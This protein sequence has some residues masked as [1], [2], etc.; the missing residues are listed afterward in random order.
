VKQEKEIFNELKKMAKAY[1]H[2]IVK[3]DKKQI[4]MIEK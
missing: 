3:D 4:K 1:N 2:F